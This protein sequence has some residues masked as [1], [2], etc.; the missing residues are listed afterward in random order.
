MKSV[1]EEEKI[2]LANANSYGGTYDK[3]KEKYPDSPEL[4]PQLKKEV[5]RIDF[6]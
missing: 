3:I 4:S 5:I 6:Y 2:K 1:I